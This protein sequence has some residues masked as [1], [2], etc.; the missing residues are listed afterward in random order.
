LLAFSRRADVHPTP[1]DLGAVARESVGLLRRLVG[2]HVVVRL[3]L[4][5]GVPC[6][7]ADRVQID[8]VLLNLAA[9]ARDAMPAGGQLRI[10]VRPT[11]LTKSFVRSHPGAHAGPHV[12]LEVSDTGVGMDDAT[13]AHLFEPFFTTKPR[14]QGTG[15]GLASVYGIVKQASGYI[16]VDSRPA[17][18]SAFRVYL[19]ALEDSATAVTREPAAGRSHRRGA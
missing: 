11:K 14:G 13:K 10:A 3:A 12:L 18:G 2:E 5:T 17:G 15:L 1:L 8:Q 16:D 19:P 6:V 4:D 7:L 9:N